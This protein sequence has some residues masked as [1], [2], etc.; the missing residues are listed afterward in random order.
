MKKDF[1]II[2]KN[3]DVTKLITVL[4]NSYYSDSYCGE[5]YDYAALRPFIPCIEFYCYPSKGIEKVLQYY[6][7]I[8]RPYIIW[9]GTYE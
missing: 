9:K 7:A 5:K 3:P 1:T 6:K 2:I 4:P 8:N